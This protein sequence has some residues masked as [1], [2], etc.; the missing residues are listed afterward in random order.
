MAPEFDPTLG[1]DSPPVKPDPGAPA[2]GGLRGYAP[3]VTE[4]IK[5]IFDIKGLGRAVDRQGR[6]YRVLMA[7]AQ[8]ETGLDES[9]I[10]TLL[11]FLFPG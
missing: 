10:E 5:A 9:E 7:M 4:T 11:G 3:H 1:G 6:H 8:A 2:L